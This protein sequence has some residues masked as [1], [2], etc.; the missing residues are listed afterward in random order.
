MTPGLLPILYFGAA[1]LIMFG[2]A[3]VVL[4]RHLLRAVFAIALLEAGVNL[5]LLLA[6]Y[7]PGFIAP[8]LDKGPAGVMA[9]PI[10]QALVLTAI[11][12][13]VGVLALMLSLVVRVKL[14][15]GTLD[16]RH[17]REGMERDI[18]QA[19]ATGM[20]TSDEAPRATPAAGEPGG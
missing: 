5:L 14:A 15:Y 13:G 4:S 19:T 9:D 16:M 8:I 18:A 10:P 17:L 20:P 7:R 6:G 12:I 2:I 1:G 11:V 3:G